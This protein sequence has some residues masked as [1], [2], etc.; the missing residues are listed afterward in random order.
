MLEAA[1]DLINAVGIPATPADLEAGP[2][3]NQIAFGECI[4]RV[5]EAAAQIDSLADGWLLANFVA[6][7]WR[8]IKATRNLLTHHYWVADFTILH[9]I[10]TVHLRAVTEPVAAYLGLPDPYGPGEPAP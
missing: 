5:G 2:R 9:T 6:V 1:D 8:D 10:A 3:I 4:R 7:P